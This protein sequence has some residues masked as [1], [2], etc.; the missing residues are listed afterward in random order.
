MTPVGTGNNRRP[1]GVRPGRSMQA[2]PSR[3]PLCVA[4]GAVLGLAGCKDPAPTTSVDAAGS[5][6]APQAAPAPS[7]AIPAPPPRPIDAELPTFAGGGPRPLDRRAECAKDVCTLLYLVPDEVRPALSDGAP[8][9]LWE[10]AL[11]ER[12]SVV[13]PRDE[14]VELLGIVLEG[15]VDLTPMDAPTARTVGGRWAAFRAPGGGVTL[16]GTGGKAARMA[17][18]VAV[19]ERGASLGAHLDRR[20]RKGT[21]GGAP[22]PPEWSWKVRRKRVDVF[23]F[24]D[25][26]DLA[27]GAGAYHA[28]IG[29]E[30]GKYRFGAGGKTWEVD[31]APAAVIDLLRFAPDAA[32]AEHSHETAWETVAL[33]EGE[34]TW[35]RKGASGEGRVEARPGTIVTLPPNVRHA[36]SPSGQ[37]PFLAIQVYAPPGPEQRFK[38][39][40]GKAP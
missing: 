8:V 26:P 35:I 30:A 14:G 17:L 1:P 28:R 6:A 25:R 22:A 36:W 7:A 39:L 34:G 24:A 23:S 18:V 5:S 38:K 31:D 9:V 13:F 2:S 11:G 32:L 20:D 4:I 33:L 12:A 37:A 29:W 27:W 10:Q 3:T 21:T 19:V 40:G 15:S 16:G